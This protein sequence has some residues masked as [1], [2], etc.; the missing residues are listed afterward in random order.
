MEAGFAPVLTLVRHKRKVHELAH[1]FTPRKGGNVCPFLRGSSY[2][3][4]SQQ[5][6]LFS[7]STQTSTARSAFPTLASR[8]ALALLDLPGYSGPQYVTSDSDIVIGDKHGRLMAD[9]W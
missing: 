6:C 8:M 4:S 9:R 5:F 3:L 2:C 7:D 1:E